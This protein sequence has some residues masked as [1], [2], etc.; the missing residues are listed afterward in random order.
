M[1]KDK[2]EHNR[3]QA[4]DWLWDTIP[5]NLPLGLKPIGVVSNT[6]LRLE[7]VEL[8]HRNGFSEWVSQILLSVD[9]LKVDVT[10]IHDFSDAMVAAQNML[11]PLVCLWFLRL[12]NGS[13][14]I[15]VEQNWTNKGGSY[16][17]LGDEFLQPHRF[18]GSI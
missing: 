5:N 13:R 18:F 9:L 8:L 4:D 11:R 1:Y 15:T 7:V 14:A 6:H 3:Q 17:E 12:S 2:N 16:S 10:S